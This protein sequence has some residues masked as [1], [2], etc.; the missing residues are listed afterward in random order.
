MITKQPF[1]PELLTDTQLHA[2]ASMQKGILQ[3]E[4]LVQ[5]LNTMIVDHQLPVKHLAIV[6]H[7]AGRMLYELEGVLFNHDCDMAKLRKAAGAS[8]ERFVS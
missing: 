5:R 4:K 1:Y 8:P 7:E 6:G 2:V 3:L